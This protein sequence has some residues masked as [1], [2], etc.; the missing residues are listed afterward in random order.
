MNDKDKQIEKLKK[1]KALAERGI[2]GEKEGAL[3]LYN[4]LL[5]KY[6]LTESDF[7]EEKVE[8][9]WVRFKD[10]I[11]AKLIIQLFYKV[12]GDR[13][14]YEK[15]DRR[16]NLVGFDCTEFEYNQ[17]LFY[18]DFYKEHL[19]NELDVFISAFIRVNDLYPDETARV[20]DDEDEEEEKT[21]EEMAKDLIKSAKIL[22]MAKGM[23]AQTPR[24]RIEDKEE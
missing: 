10:Y 23:D 15:I 3:Q 1:I 13:T 14:S 18:Y 5:A 7:L 8:T 24:L 12:T 4:K 16:I 17:F 6:E 20:K 19:Q 2:G 21:P 22:E 11:D 9:H